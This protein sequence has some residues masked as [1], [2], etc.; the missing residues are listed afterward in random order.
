MRVDHEGGTTAWLT[1]TLAAQ[2]VQGQGLSLT[3]VMALS[4]YFYEP[5]VT[6]DQKPSL[7]SLSLQLCQFRHLEGSLAFSVVPP[8]K[9]SEG[10]LWLGSYSIDQYVKHLKRH[11]GWGPTL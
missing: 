6:G 5:L 11:P 10:P 9:H 7:I 8:I 1:G 4:E 3:G 2:S